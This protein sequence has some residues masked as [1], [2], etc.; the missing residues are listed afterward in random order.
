M[1]RAS[2]QRHRLQ[3]AARSRARSLVGRE[4]GPLPPIRDIARRKRARTDLK[5]FLEAYFPRVFNKPFGHNHLTLIESL[6]RC[7]IDGGRQAVA[8]PRGSGKTSITTH[9]AIWAAV[10]GHRRMEIIFAATQ[11][12]AR[13][14]LQRIHKA[15]RR[16]PSP[17][18][19]DYPEVCVPFVELG[20]SALLARGQLCSGIP[21]QISVS[22]D[23][24]V[25]P[26]VTG[27]LASGSVISCVGMTGSFLGENTDL[28]D[29]R[30]VR[31]DFLMLDDLQ[32]DDLAKNPARVDDLENKINA[33]LEGLVELGAELSM[34]MTCTVK[35]PGDLSDRFLDHERYPRWNGI[36]G[37]MIEQ[38]P[39]R[40]D[41]WREYRGRRHN[42]ESDARAFYL[43]H[44]DEMR[45]GAVVGWENCHDPRK[46]VDS[47][48]YAMNRWCDNE[49]AFWSEYQNEPQRD[50]GAATVVPARV[51][52]TRLSGY[53]RA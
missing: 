53:D 14:I 30:N 25:F 3:M 27:S 23:R 52:M 21:T 20:G 51:I 46:F 34:V 47:L 15:L 13:K 6:Q 12:A 39:E 33:S 18:L 31:P 43:A 4:I 8:L 16:S 24:L 32:K 44:L 26:C 19:D 41:L 37:K 2:Y 42:D 5:Y 10:N 49:R 48:E 36:R 40:M 7:L 11:N 22:A 38:W 45:A 50:P 1:D 35:A 29:G 28:P 17:L 9:A